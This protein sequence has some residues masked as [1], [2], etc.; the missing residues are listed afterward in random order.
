MDAPSLAISKLS[1][2]PWNEQQILQCLNN[3]CQNIT[4]IPQIL[5]K[6]LTYTLDISEVIPAAE[7]SA[8]H[9]T[10]VLPPYKPNSCIAHRT[11]QR[12][13]WR[14]IFEAWTTL[15]SIN[16]F[17]SRNWLVIHRRHVE[18]CEFDGIKRFIKIEKNLCC[19]CNIPH[20]GT[21]HKAHCKFYLSWQIDSKPL[22]KSSCHTWQHCLFYNTKKP[23]NILTVITIGYGKI[24]EAVTI[25]LA[26]G[27][28]FAVAVRLQLYTK[29]QGT[30]YLAKCI[31]FNVLFCAKL[32]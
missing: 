18:A 25:Q 9:G 28:A 2:I 26:S 16:L 30:C 5:Y 8:L 31:N 6:S 1:L 15:K 32:Q 12:C 20:K 4:Y 11:S 7:I 29:N 3:S 17:I 23:N 27:Q 22:K 13:C 14:F 19:G 21:Q 24:L 10:F